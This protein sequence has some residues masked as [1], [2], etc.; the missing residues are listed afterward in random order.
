[1]TKGW[2]YASLSGVAFLFVMALIYVWNDG[3][4]AEHDAGQDVRMDRIENRLDQLDGRMSSQDEVITSVRL[5]LIRI[6]TTLEHIE[7]Q[8]DKILTSL[9]R[10]AQELIK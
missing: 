7:S 5:E 9:D 4:S 8:Q 6:E 1:M 3:G 2:W 10:L